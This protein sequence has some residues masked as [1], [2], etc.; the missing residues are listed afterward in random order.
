V[1]FDV[2]CAALGARLLIVGFA[3][4]KTPVIPA[5]ILLARNLDALGVY[6]GAY[7]TEPRYAF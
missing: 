3:S 1:V 5:N 4:G 7:L 2:R 6:V